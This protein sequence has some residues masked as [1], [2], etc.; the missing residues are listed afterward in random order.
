[1]IELLQ[2]GCDI[3]PITSSLPHKKKYEIPEV[4][5]ST[6]KNLGL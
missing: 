2:L 3:D 4:N 1:M 5:V 6:P